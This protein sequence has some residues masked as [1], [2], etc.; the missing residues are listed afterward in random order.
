MEE[1]LEFN[2]ESVKKGIAQMFYLLIWY[3][4]RKLYKCLNA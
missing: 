1:T 4:A 2:Y 3:H